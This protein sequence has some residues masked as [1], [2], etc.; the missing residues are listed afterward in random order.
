MSNYVGQI[1][2]WIVKPW[3]G[4][5]LAQLQA[6]PKFADHTAGRRGPGHRPAGKMQIGAIRILR[7]G[8]VDSTGTGWPNVHDRRIIDRGPLMASDLANVTT[9][10]GTT[11]PN[12]YQYNGGGVGGPVFYDVLPDGT[13][14][15]DFTFLYQQPGGAHVD[16]SSIMPATAVPVFKTWPNTE[17]QYF[18]G[19]NYVPTSTLSA[20]RL[21]VIKSNRAALGI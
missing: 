16:P 20:L 18:W 14:S 3:Q 15:E 21:A 13:P 1:T 5:T 19:L 10:M 11:E 9:W 2:W 6:L 4:M 17:K 8:E 7:I 12:V